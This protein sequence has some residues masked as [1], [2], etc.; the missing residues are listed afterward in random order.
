MSECQFSILLN[1]KC[2]MWSAVDHVIKK[3]DKCN[4]IRLACG[5]SWS[6]LRK[7]L[8]EISDTGKQSSPTPKAIL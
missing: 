2:E 7:Q 4:F 3:Y 1:D 6:D 8:K 5:E